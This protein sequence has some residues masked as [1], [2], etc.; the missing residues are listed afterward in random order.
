MRKL[1]ALLPVMLLLIAQIA[2]AQ[3]DIVNT[4]SNV[5]VQFSGVIFIIAFVIILLLIAGVFPRIS[6]GGFGIPWGTI[7]LLIAILIVMVVPFFV[8]LEW[9]TTQFNVTL[10]QY[11]QSPLPS[12]ATTVLSD[13]LGLPKEWMY[14][15]AIIYFFILPFAA[16]FALIY[17]F[18]ASLNIW[19][20]KNN[21]NRLLAFIITIMTIPTGILTR[22]TMVMFVFLGMW[23][24]A[25]FFVTFVVGVFYRGAG[26]IVRERM[27]Y[28][29]MRGPL[30]KLAEDFRK[31]ADGKLKNLRKGPQLDAL[32][33]VRDEIMEKIYLGEITDLKAAQDEFNKDY[34]RIGGG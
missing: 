10:A 26:V 27:T 30:A 6:I 23:T 14:L 22:M 34:N 19:G 3:Q 13:W 24:L 5:L 17:A 33:R 11:Q 12:E 32:R 31:Y 7:G 15:P 8:N 18:L 29:A 28:K 21:I 16:V 9:L 25:V 2:I 1:L 4:I 20:G